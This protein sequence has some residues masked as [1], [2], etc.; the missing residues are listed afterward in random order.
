MYLHRFLVI[1]LKFVIYRSNTPARPE[2]ST[3]RLCLI[4]V[5]AVARLTVSDMLE[6]DR[7]A[8]SRTMKYIFS[9][10]DKI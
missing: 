6:G 7:I 9:L 8:V 4:V 3:S 1:C 2:V 10:A 5:G